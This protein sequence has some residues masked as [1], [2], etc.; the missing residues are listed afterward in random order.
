MFT[1]IVLILIFII[2]EIGA[3][4][5]IKKFSDTGF[6]GSRP[7]TEKF[8]PYKGWT[9]SPFKPFDDIKTDE[10]GRA[11]VTSRKDGPKVVFLGGSAI[12]GVGQTSNDK[13]IASVLSNLM[14]MQGVNISAR[15]YRSFQLMLVLREYFLYEKADTVILIGGQIDPMYANTEPDR[16]LLPE[17]VWSKAAF[18]NRAEEELPILQ[19]V[20][21]YF[22]QYSY[23][24]DVFCRMVRKLIRKP[25][26]VYTPQRK[27][28][29]IPEQAKRTLDHYHMIKALVERNGAKFYLV[30]QPIRT[31]RTFLKMYYDEVWEHGQDII[32]LN[33]RDFLKPDKHFTDNAHYTDEGAKLV[34][35]EIYDEIR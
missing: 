26:P 30:L 10:K 3:Y 11:I 9:T 18:I 28:E 35:E 31:D 21:G 2:C 5:W 27:F 15:A 34:A 4:F 13:T 6:Y 32:D 22:R 29:L 8:H 1:G 23:S 12:V 25:G 20:D 17:D 14:D 16:P 24:F 7:V 33:L 19:N